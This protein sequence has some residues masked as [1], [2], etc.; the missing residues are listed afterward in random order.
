MALLLGQ[1]L[2]FQILHV[3]VVYQ[4]LDHSHSKYI[5][6]YSWYSHGRGISKC[7][8]T[9]RGWRL[10]GRVRAAYTCGTGQ[11]DQ[12]SKIFA[13]QCIVNT[14]IWGEDFRLGSEY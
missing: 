11:S 7:G 9:L 5:N 14:G 4:I 3:L 1:C 8:H 10:G 6:K 2:S 13:D 12:V